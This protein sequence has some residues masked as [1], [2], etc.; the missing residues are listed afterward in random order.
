VQ[1]HVFDLFTQAK[2]TPDRAQGGL[3]IGLALVKSIVELHHGSVEVFSAG[4]DQGSTL[5]VRLPRAHADLA[6]TEAAAPALQ[7]PFVAL[8]VLVV[9]DNVDA[10]ELLAMALGAHGHAVAVEHGASAA[11]AQVDRCVP[12]V[13]VLDIGMP[14]IDG[15]ALARALRELPATRDALLVA[16]TGYGTRHDRQTALAAGFDHYFV[17]PVD[18]DA[19]LQMIAAASNSRVQHSP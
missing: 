15:N 17:K 16:V 1:Q 2:R 14:N 13:C 18:I 5:T 10:A 3:G 12:D 9:D 19:L 11:L 8:D 7:A 4:L 6:Q